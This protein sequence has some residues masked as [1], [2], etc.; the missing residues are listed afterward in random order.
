MTSGFCG[1]RGRVNNSELD[2][3]GP[4]DA[5]LLPACAHIVITTPRFP[6]GA[7]LVSVA[8]EEETL[9]GGWFNARGILGGGESGNLCL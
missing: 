1:P 9:S 5:A 4:F 6:T 2:C 8:G 7:R 3:L